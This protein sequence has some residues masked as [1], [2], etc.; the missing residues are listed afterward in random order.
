M[1][2]ERVL[3]VGL[4]RR[5]GREEKIHSLEELASLV[6]TAGGEVVETIVQKRD[7]PDPAYFIGKGK[8]EEIKELVE[9]H[10]IDTV[11]F[12][13]P[14]TPAQVRNLEK[15]IGVKII[16]RRDVILDI[17][18]QHARTRTA[19]IEVELAQLKFKLPRIYGRGEELSRLGGG[20]GTRGP[21]EKKL[22]VDRRRIKERIK[23]LTGE[24]KRIE[25]SREI[26]RKRRKG[27][28]R[29]ALVGY[30][31]AG[32]S[33][34]MNALSHADVYVDDKLFATLDPTTRLVVL[35]TGEKFLVT[36][37]VGFIRNIPPQL[38]ASFHATLE[39]AVEAD[40]R[41]WVVDVSHPEFE[42]HIKETERIM[43]NLGCRDKPYII[44][45]NKIDLLWD[46]GIMERLSHLYPGCMF[47]SAKTGEGIE[48]LKERIK[49]L[50]HEKKEVRVG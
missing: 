19:K 38:V 3:L 11:V 45:F 7:R 18:A 28:F 29:V 31:N 43:E 47:I 34:L 37:T 15:L 46:R 20:I 10:E 14:L 33:T 9:K 17:F 5:K 39:E 22:E 13:D 32:K 42:R 16:D 36:D 44:V 26:Q 50:I 23:K 6:K 49:K 12:D 21:G 30:T 41:L 1:A 24:L 8:A 35:P 40:L 4:L 27:L 48:E 2:K 25:K